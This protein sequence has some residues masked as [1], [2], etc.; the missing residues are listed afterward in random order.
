MKINLKAV[1]SSIENY[2]VRD[3]QKAT[4][5]DNSTFCYYKKGRNYLK[6]MT[7]KNLS[8][9]TSMSPIENEEESFVAD[10][11]TFNEF[12]SYYNNHKELYKKHKIFD[13]HL[14]TKEKDSLEKISL[15][16]FYNL[17]VSEYKLID[18]TVKFY[19]KSSKINQD[20][21]LENFKNMI[22]AT[23]KN[24]RTL[25]LELDKPDNYISHFIARHNKGHY[26]T[27]TSV[28]TWKLL[29]KVL[30]NGNVNEF[31]KQLFKE[32]ID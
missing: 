12:K 19:N 31:K 21:V 30:T 17:T 32:N 9:L 14:T 24:G 15:K 20:Q 10:E 27:Y 18:K 5:L 22:K 2:K 3:L 25:S 28:P 1:N 4:G 13:F 11:N 29:A 23:G 26:L 6:T 16:D 8:I 7:L